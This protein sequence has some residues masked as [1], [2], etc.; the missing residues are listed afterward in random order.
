MGKLGENFDMGALNP[1][2]AEF[3][4][5]PNLF[6]KLPAPY[7]WLLQETSSCIGA[8]MDHVY[9]LDRAVPYTFFA[10]SQ[11]RLIL[12][13]GAPR[14]EDANEEGFKN[15]KAV[16]AFIDDVREFKSVNNRVH[17]LYQNKPVTPKASE[18]LQDAVMPEKAVPK[19]DFVLDDV[20]LISA[21]IRDVWNICND[22][23]ELHDP[24]QRDE[25]E[26]KISVCVAYH[27][28]LISQ[29]DNKLQMI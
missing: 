26:H 22:L 21:D 3:Q 6:D 27:E 14:L 7:Q 25:I 5:D 29:R 24:A 17:F 9:E 1:L 28:R 18:T 15:L 10:A 19:D 4:G 2:V 16:Q 11:T 13:F 23:L 8:M 12:F 20:P